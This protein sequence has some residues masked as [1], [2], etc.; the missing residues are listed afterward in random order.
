MKGVLWILHA[1]G[2]T[3]LTPQNVKFI[4]YRPV[5]DNACL[6]SEFGYTPRLDARAVFERY[7]DERLE[8]KS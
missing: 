2:L 8:P 1:L 6:K 4:Q 7:R 5:L 3:K